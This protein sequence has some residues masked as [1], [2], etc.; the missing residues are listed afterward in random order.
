MG[1]FSV[2][3]DLLRDVV[4]NG[5][6]PATSKARS[7]EMKSLAGLSGNILATKQKLFIASSFPG[8]SILSAFTLIN[9]KIWQSGYLPLGKA[10]FPPVEEG[11]I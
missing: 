4:E 3:L 5:K 8:N 7:Q 10:L 2:M 9:K 6:W 11:C 1:A